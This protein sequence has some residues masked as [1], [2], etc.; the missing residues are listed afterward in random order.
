MAS[1]V[2]N[3]FHTIASLP[4]LKWWDRLFSKRALSIPA[5]LLVFPETDTLCAASDIWMTLKETSSGDT[6]LRDTS[7]GDTKKEIRTEPPPGAGELLDLLRSTIRKA[8]V[9]GYSKPWLETTIKSM[10]RSYP[11]LL[12][13]MQEVAI[14]LF[15]SRSVARHCP[16]VFDMDELRM[17]WR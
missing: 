3:P 4:L 12:G 2:N 1:T 17:L 11:H 7:L 15:I 14:L 13:T 6:S 5:H 8:A 16:Y 9:L 10:L